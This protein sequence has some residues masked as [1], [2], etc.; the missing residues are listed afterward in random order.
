MNV[1]AKEVVT[2]LTERNQ[3]IA[4][5]ESLTGGLLSS[6][7]TDIPGTSH[8][9]IGSIIAYSIDIKVRELGVSRETLDQFGVV[10]EPVAFD[11]AEG[12][13]KK[14]GSTWAVATTGIAGPGPSHGIPAGTVWIA[15]IGPGVR[16]AIALSLEGDRT[17]VRRGAVDSALAALAR[18]LRA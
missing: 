11:M 3:T 15:I 8:V 13:S 14:F 6:A 1:L 12:I 10:S 2:S 16:E 5:A 9:F 7:L 18:I 17:E 4:I